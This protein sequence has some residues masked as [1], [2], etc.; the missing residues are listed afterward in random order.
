MGQCANTPQPYS[1]QTAWLI[2]FKKQNASLKE[3]LQNG[4]L[5]Y[6]EDDKER[7][8]T[9]GLPG[10]ALP[11][12][13]LTHKLRYATS[14]GRF[15]ERAS[16]FCASFSS[17]SPHS[18]S[19]PCL[20]LVFTPSHAQIFSQVIQ[21]TVLSM[22]RLTFASGLQKGQEAF[23][24]FFFPTRPPSLNSFTQQN[25]SLLLSSLFT[26]FLYLYY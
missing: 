9:A 5:R 13:A 25:T 12:H 3:H 24:F 7:T 18:L 4:T 10:K 16:D 2:R 15:R 22:S 21:I 8:K 19:V 11:T 20:S 1:A 26:Q 14:S 23:F 17:S 6:E